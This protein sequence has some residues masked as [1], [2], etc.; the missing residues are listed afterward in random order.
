M[1]NMG[2]VWNMLTLEQLRQ[3][4]DEQ[5]AQ[6]VNERLV[7]LGAPV[8]GAFVQPADFLAAQYYVGE[9]DRR[10]NLRV[11]VER[12]RIETKRRRIDLLL[13]GLI[14]ALIGVEIFLGIQ[15][16][17][18][19]S[20]QAAKELEAFGNLQTVLAN[21]QQ[22]SQAT[23]DTLAQLKTATD[24]INLAT[25]GQL[26]VSFD[27]S[28]AVKFDA[29]H[30]LDVLNNGRTNITLWGSLI[31]GEGPVFLKVP[32]VLPPNGGYEF[33]SETLYSQLAEKFRQTGTVSVK[34]EVYVKNELGTKFVVDCT[35]TFLKDNFG[36][37]LVAQIN[38]I[39]RRDWQAK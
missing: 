21:L 10:E 17:H 7:P 30:K 27:P 9:L 35:F 12:D 13:E 23:A 38:A 19:Q 11:N 16:G 31:E 32:S 5:V 4:S 2:G 29:M 8:Q 36:E 33:N 22:S 37:R 24:S 25:Q 39:S 34:Y 6:R 1:E 28:V 26:A 15:A 18:Q 20:R 14:V 3:L